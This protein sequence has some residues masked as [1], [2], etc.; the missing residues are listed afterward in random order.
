MNVLQISVLGPTQTLV[1]RGGRQ[2]R[3]SLGN[4]HREGLPEGEGLDTGCAPDRFVYLS[5][6]EG[7]PACNRAPHLALSLFSI[8]LGAQAKW[9]HKRSLVSGAARKVTTAPPLV[10]EDPKGTACFLSPWGHL[11][12]FQFT[13][14]WCRGLR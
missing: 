6:A 14:K 4:F 9:E 5:K 13:S 1:C 3:Q 2:A 12:H 7:G 8:R 10:H 11:F